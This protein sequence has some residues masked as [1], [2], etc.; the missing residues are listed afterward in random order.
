MKILES[1][2]LVTIRQ[3]HKSSK[4]MTKILY[5]PNPEAM[6]YRNHL[7]QCLPSP[8][9]FLIK[10]CINVMSDYSSHSQ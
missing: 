1:N 5:V 8:P 3:G 4:Q 10:F 6:L 9:K 7:F 2:K